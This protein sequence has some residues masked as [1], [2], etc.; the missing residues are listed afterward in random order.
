MK[1]WN[2]TKFSAGV[3][4]QL[5]GSHLQDRIRRRELIRDIDRSHDSISAGNPVLGR[6]HLESARVMDNSETDQKYRGE[7]NPAMN[8][9]ELR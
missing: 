2:P 9:Y 5:R 6:K 1:G 8:Q 4:F 7:K 3:R